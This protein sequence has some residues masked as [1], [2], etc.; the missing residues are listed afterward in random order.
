MSWNIKDIIESYLY[1]S[2]YNAG[3]LV[4][5]ALICSPLCH[6]YA[7]CKVNSSVN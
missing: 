2:Y 7:V 3:N 1:V 4:E 6:F 5:F